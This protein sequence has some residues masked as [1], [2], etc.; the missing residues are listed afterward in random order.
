MAFRDLTDV[1]GATRTKELPIHGRKVAF[2]GTVSAWAGQLLMAIRHAAEESAAAGS[3]DA[4]PVDLVLASGA[5]TEAD[6][7]EL[8]RE[9][10]GDGA[11]VLDELGVIGEARA[12][13][14]STLVAWHLGG[15]EAALRAWEAGP[16]GK[17]PAPNRATRRRMAGS[18]SKTGG[19]AKASSRTA[20]GDSPARRATGSRG[21]RS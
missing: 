20:A 13:V 18:S 16:K 14:A 3:P 1:L 10:F 6:A 5:A 9:L 2:P 7:L 8:E 11:A 17:A 12:H 4:D 15:E 21:T 19:T